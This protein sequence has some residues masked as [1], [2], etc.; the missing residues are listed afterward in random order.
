MAHSEPPKPLRLFVFSHPRTASNLF[1]KLFS[2]HP[3]INQQLYVFLTEHFY[4]PEAQTQIQSERMNEL[5][6][7]QREAAKGLTYQAAL[8]KME[9]QIADFEAQVRLV[10]RYLL[11]FAL[12]F[13]QGKLPMLKEH[14]CFVTGAAQM[15]KMLKRHRE[16]PPKPV[17]VD[18]HLDLPPE[19]RQAVTVANLLD[20][21]PVVPN[22]T[23]LP[24]RL[25]KTFSPIILIR[26]PAKQLE[27][28]YK[29]S[30]IF[31][32]AVNDADFELVSTY[33]FSRSVF[34]YYVA[35]HGGPPAAIQKEKDAA[36]MNSRWPIVI[37]GD[38][39][40]ND[41]ERI[42]NIICE[43]TGL[44]PSGV[45]YKWEQVDP[46]KNSTEEA[47]IGTL[48]KSEGIKKNLVSL[49]LSRIHK[50]STRLIRRSQC[51]KKPDLVQ[52]SARWR[53]EW[54]HEVADILVEYAEDALIDYEYLY[55]F[56]L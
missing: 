53:E 21:D 18:H 20:G 49:S 50:S 56:K 32:V 28:W 7:V 55:Q 47:F 52:S 24:D 43:L 27:S 22:P 19:Q 25:M 23:F 30:R 51:I 46:P 39:L 4:G 35:L 9:K 10:L 38:D 37:D 5:S 34:E 29:A 1:C 26:H 45:I 33:K 13:K 41:T 3:Q 31:G 54:G 6:K 40:I 12:N 2:Q 15:L 11:T 42:A 8:D 16:V 14:C 17:M 36:K 48:H 44:E